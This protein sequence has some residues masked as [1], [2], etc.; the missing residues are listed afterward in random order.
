MV[1]RIKYLIAVQEQVAD[2]Q[3]LAAEARSPKRARFLRTLADD[4]EAETR[5]E[6]LALCSPE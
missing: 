1:D 2:L 3:R 5:S 4:L 6:D